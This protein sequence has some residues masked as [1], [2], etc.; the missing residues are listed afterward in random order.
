MSAPDDEGGAHTESVDVSGEAEAERNGSVAQVESDPGAGES[1]SGDPPA[2]V[3]GTGTPSRP[4]SGKGR[5]RAQTAQE[6]QHDTW[7]DAMK[8]MRR[9]AI[10]SYS[11]RVAEVGPPACCSAEQRHHDNTCRLGT[12]KLGYA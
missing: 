10:A 7:V 8:E 5:G 9:E 12:A 1:A 11:A 6:V 4:H 3:D 2:G